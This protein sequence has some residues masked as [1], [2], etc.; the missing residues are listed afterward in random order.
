MAGGD[1]GAARGGEALS[2]ERRAFSCRAVGAVVWTSSF[3]EELESLRPI[4]AS[5][6]LQNMEFQIY[7]RDPWCRLVRNQH[8]AGRKRRSENRE[9]ILC[10]SQ[11]KPRL[12]AVG[13][14][15]LTVCCALPCC[16]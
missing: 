12:E 13:N 1:S 10:L 15:E 6:A 11:S 7:F 5:I 2:M 3:G 14:G 8:K 16:Y 9:K 4:V